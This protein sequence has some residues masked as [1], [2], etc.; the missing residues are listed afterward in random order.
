[1]K[2]LGLYPADMMGVCINYLLAFIGFY[3]FKNGLQ[4]AALAE[5]VSMIFN[6]RI[7]IFGNTQEIF[8][9]LTQAAVAVGVSMI[10]TRWAK[11]LFGILGRR[12]GSSE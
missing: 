3:I 8:G 2:T 10:F 5:G 12:C 9:H 7:Q 6:P 11:Y 4:Q 1:M